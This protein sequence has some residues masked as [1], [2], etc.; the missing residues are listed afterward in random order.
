MH[1]SIKRMVIERSILG[2]VLIN[3]FVMQIIWASCHPTSLVHFNKIWVGC[4]LDPSAENL[5]NFNSRSDGWQN[6]AIL[7]HSS[8][9]CF[10]TSEGK[11]HKRGQLQCSLKKP[12][13]KKKRNTKLREKLLVI[14][15]IC[16][17]WG[18]SYICQAFITIA[19]TYAFPGAHLASLVDRNTHTHTH[20]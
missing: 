18:H 4:K 14:K 17:I 10:V 19:L 2:S 16:S 3:L 5:H 11:N 13:G 1:P 8:T 12:L 6:W 7:L 9:I 15:R 20:I